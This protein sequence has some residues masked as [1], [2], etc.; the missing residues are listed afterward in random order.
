VNAGG[1]AATVYWNAGN[2]AGTDAIGIGTTIAVNTWYDL[3]VT[4]KGT[5]SSFYIN[6][7]LGGTDS[8]QTGTA[9]STTSTRTLSL[10][11]NP[12]GGGTKEPTT[13]DY[14]ALWDR[15]LSAAEVAQFNFD[16]FA[17]YRPRSRWWEVP[18]AA[19]AFTNRPGPRMG[20]AIPF[21]LAIGG[22]KL[23][24]RNPIIRR[25]ELFRWVKK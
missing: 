10:G 24:E 3:V 22:A 11:G 14:F 8:S 15:A 21:G 17:I 7:K 20:P 16:P 6:G 9:N 23:L 12:S 18:A 25:R 5:L 4:R 2:S 19:G 13:Y 1:G